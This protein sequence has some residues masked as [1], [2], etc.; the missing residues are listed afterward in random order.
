LVGAI[1]G[2]PLWGYG[3]F[4]IRRQVAAEDLLKRRSTADEQSKVARE[5]LARL[6]ERI[7]ARYD[8]DGADQWKRN[9]GGRHPVISGGGDWRAFGA[10]FL[11][12]WQKE[13]A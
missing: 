10:G 7:K 2:R 6:V 5:L 13:P 9:T 11:N 1:S 3:A 8:Q 12:G 4:L